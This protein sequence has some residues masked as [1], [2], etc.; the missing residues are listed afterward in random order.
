MKELQD[1]STQTSNSEVELWATLLIIFYHIR[2][3]N[4]NP[5]SQPQTDAQEHLT[6]ILRGNPEEEPNSIWHDFQWMLAKPSPV[7]R[8]RRARI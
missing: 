5:I 7:R 4:I 3:D 1:L 6:S 2:Q 8:K